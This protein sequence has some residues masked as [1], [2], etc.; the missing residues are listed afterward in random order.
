MKILAL[1]LGDKWVGSAISDGL[2]ITCKPYKTVDVEMTESFL[3]TVIKEED[4]STIVI[5]KPTTF[6]GLESEQTKKIMNT[7]KE[8]EEKINPKFNNQ[9]KWILWDE[10]LS[11]KRA[12][13]LNTKKIKTKE[14]KIKSH[15][16]AAAFILQSYLDNKA[17]QQF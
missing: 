16:V 14:D 8:L 4:I 5:G 3:E 9:I 15:S 10:R 2:G 17:F 7:A 6:S 13:S 12:E 11:S 1:D